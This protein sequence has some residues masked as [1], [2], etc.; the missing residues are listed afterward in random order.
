MDCRRVG[1]W[2]GAVAVHNLGIF[3]IQRKFPREGLS[4]FWVFPNRGVFFSKPH[5]SPSCLI[6][7]WGIHSAKEAFTQTGSSVGIPLCFFFYT[8]CRLDFPIFFSLSCLWVR[9]FVDVPFSEFHSL[10][11]TNELLC[12]RN[13]SFHSVC[14]II[15][16]NLLN[17]PDIS[18]EAL[19]ACKRARHRG[20]VLSGV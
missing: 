19:S 7:F 13:C 1:I 16:I 18:S 5:F 15:F 2:P 20:P 3:C 6:L 17:T 14:N 8:S 9:Y 4:C 12:D 11:E 10:P